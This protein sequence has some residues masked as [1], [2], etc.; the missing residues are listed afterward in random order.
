MIDS[1]TL[2]ESFATQIV[3]KLRK[4]IFLIRF[5]PLLL[6]RFFRLQTGRSGE[7]HWLEEMTNRRE[8]FSIENSSVRVVQSH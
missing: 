7:I 4:K 1:E 8:F 6:S 3:M 2:V 5:F